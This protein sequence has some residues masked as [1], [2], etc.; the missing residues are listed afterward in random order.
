MK[1]YRSRNIS[2]EEFLFGRKRNY[3][4][5]L[6]NQAQESEEKILEKQN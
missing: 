1:K 4:L 5:H 3:D 6:E 2:K